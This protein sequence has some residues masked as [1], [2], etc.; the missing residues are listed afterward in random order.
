MAAA[1]GDLTVTRGTVTVL[2]VVVALP[3]NSISLRHDFFTPD[4]PAPPSHPT[5]HA[6]LC[7]SRA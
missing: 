7:F 4:I 2:P 5:P 1:L 6:D 3:D